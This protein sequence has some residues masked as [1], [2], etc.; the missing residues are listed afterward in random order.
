MI[1]TY[2]SFA[3][4][5]GLGDILFPAFEKQCDCKLRVLPSVDG[6]QMMSRLEID[7][8]REKTTAHL[9]LGIDQQIWDKY[10]PLLEEW[11]GWSPDAY[12]KVPED[13]RVGP[14]FMPFDYGVMAFML[15]KKFIYQKDVQ[16]PKTLKDLLEPTWKRKIAL[17]DPRA[18]TPG[19]CFL[20]YTQQ[21][22]KENF[23]NFW[24]DMRSQWLTLAPGWD[25][26]YGLFLK[27]EA[28]LVWS[29]TTSQ[30]YHR[31]HGDQAGRY[32]ALVF[33]DGNPVQIEGAALVK[34]A[35]KTDTERA[36]A[37]RFLSFLL[38]P[39]I[40]S[41]IPE[42]NWMLPVVKTT[43]IPPSFEGLP[44]AKKLIRLPTD[45]K[46]IDD[47]IMTWAKSIR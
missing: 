5:G 21:I 27:G 45:A 39:E 22:M 16:L 40:Q 2:D 36:L 13:L 35:L 3:A 46:A 41:A 23:V 24:K 14:G 47:T 20:L 6:A 9:V 30:A 10:R 31:K 8:K 15:D 11:Q 26:A 37:I 7:R 28:A 32:E 38:S 29:Y 4:K 1:Y 18:S 34:G 43:A 19:L 25:A 42:S 12:A 44:Q 17:Q 33:E